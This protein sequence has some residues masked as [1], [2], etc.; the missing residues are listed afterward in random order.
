LSGDEEFVPNGLPSSLG[1]L[2]KWHDVKFIFRGVLSDFS[3]LQALVETEIF[4][5]DLKTSSAIVEEVATW[6]RLVVPEFGKNRDQWVS[7]RVC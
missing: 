4:G 5:D 6:L 1:R 3:L 7:S 2:L